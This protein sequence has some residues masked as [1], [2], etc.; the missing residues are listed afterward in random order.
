MIYINKCIVKKK[1]DE[2][3]FYIFMFYIFVFCIIYINMLK[4]KWGDNKQ[5]FEI[6]SL[7]FGEKN[8]EQSKDGI[9]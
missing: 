5:C 6:K 2:K 9:L 4:M 8:L 1:K 7:E 3:R